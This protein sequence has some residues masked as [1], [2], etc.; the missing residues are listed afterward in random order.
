MLPVPRTSKVPFLYIWFRRT[1]LDLTGPPPPVSQ[2]RATIPPP[3]SD[4]RTKTAPNKVTDILEEESEGQSHPASPALPHTTYKKQQLA[5]QQVKALQQRVQQTRKERDAA[6][7]RAAVSATH[8][9]D[10][11]YKGTSQPLH[12]PAPPPIPP[13]AFESLYHQ[14]EVNNRLLRKELDDKDSTIR[15]LTAEL[16]HSRNQVKGLQLE[17][18]VVNKQKCDSGVQSLNQ[19]LHNRGLRDQLDFEIYKAGTQATYREGVAAGQ[20]E[21]QR[22]GI[23]E[24][25]HFAFPNQGGQK[26]GQKRPPPPQ[27]TGPNSKQRRKAAREQRQVITAGNAGTPEQAL[28]PTPAENN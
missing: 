10:K 28:G 26:R 6:Q 25:L 17:L 3:P 11:R 16:D 24:G 8:N 19:S 14:H 13:E 20:L 15:T 2:S 27:T 7:L 23:F 18:E 9:W 21:G 22:K 1:S 5:A 12:Q 4:E